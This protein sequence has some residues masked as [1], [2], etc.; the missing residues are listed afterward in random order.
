MNTQ[1]NNH[2]LLL[3]DLYLYVE[4]IS[5][6]EAYGRREI[7]TT[8][9]EGGKYIH[10]ELGEYVPIQL[11]FK[12]K[13]YYPSNKRDKYNKKFNELQNKIVRVTSPE[14]GVFNARVQITPSWEYKGAVSLD[15]KVTEST[16]EP[17]TPK[18]VDPIDTQKADAEA[19]K[20]VSAPAVES[21][22]VKPQSKDDKNKKSTPKS[23]KNKSK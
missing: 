10:E 2:S 7:K 9:I 22:S 3:D 21:K 17:V 8:A 18:Y 11:T 23:S 13:L 1:I 5:A 16:G 6:D 12:S 15:V 14:I 20:S 19:R 4:S